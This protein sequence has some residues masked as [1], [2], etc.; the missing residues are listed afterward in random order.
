MPVQ[1]G[2]YEAKAQLS[3]LL[4]EVQQGERFIITSRGRPVA[5]LG[6]VRESKARDMRAAI[7]RMRAIERVRGIDGETIASWVAEGR[8]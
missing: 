3:R 8:R 5:E 2:S 6:P 4:R 7:E 1:I